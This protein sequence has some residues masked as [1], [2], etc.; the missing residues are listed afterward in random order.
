MAAKVTDACI[1]AAGRFQ[2]FFSL[3][4]LISLVGSLRHGLPTKRSMLKAAKSKKELELELQKKKDAKEKEVKD[5]EGKKKKGKAD[6]ASAGSDASAAAAER[7]ADAREEEGEL[8]LDPRRI[9]ALEMEAQEEVQP[10]G[11]VLC[12][13][14]LSLAELATCPDLFQEVP[15]R[16]GEKHGG[17]FGSLVTSVEAAKYAYSGA[18]KEGAAQQLGN[19]LVTFLANEG[20]FKAVHCLVMLVTLFACFLSTMGVYSGDMFT[21]T[22]VQVRRVLAAPAALLPLIAFGA[23]RAEALVKAGSALLSKELVVALRAPL[24]CAGLLAASS[25]TTESFFMGQMASLTGA[26][27]SNEA[28][29][30]LVRRWHQGS[31]PAIEIWDPALFSEGLPLALTAVYLVFAQRWCF[32]QL[33]MG[34]TLGLVTNE[35][36]LAELGAYLELQNYFHL[37]DQELVKMVSCMYGLSLGALFACAG[38]LVLLGGMLVFN[39]L[40]RLHAREIEKLG[41]SR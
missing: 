25:Q 29:W 10:G 33:L 38:P 21:S 16:K 39:V 12:I 40:F 5:K 11:G 41:M 18:E 13:L 6:A 28:V 30:K 17:P 37:F 26:V 27:F 7:A 8:R 4:S 34:V 19:A 3:V 15:K 32:R 31:L 35:V 1:S 23:L 14:L 20:T 24:R 36:I 22:R 9:A 2:M